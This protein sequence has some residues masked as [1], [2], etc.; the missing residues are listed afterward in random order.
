MKPGLS[1][2]V[3]FPQPINQS[4]KI[5]IVYEKVI[6]AKWPRQERLSEITYVPVG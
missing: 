4:I 1:V 6:A 3:A 5:T 2:R